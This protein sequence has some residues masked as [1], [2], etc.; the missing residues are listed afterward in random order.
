M[1]SQHAKQCVSIVSI[2]MSQLKQLN[3]SVTKSLT[4]VSNQTGESPKVRWAESLVE[5]G[6]S[7]GRV[8]HQFLR[9]E[10]QLD[11]SGGVLHRVAAVDNVPDRRTVGEA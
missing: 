3:R 9:F 6:L 1:F 4:I 2:S 8:R 5:P 11:L 7:A 10:P